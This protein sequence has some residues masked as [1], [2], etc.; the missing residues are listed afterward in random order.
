[1]DLDGID[2]DLDAVVEDAY[3]LREM[4]HDW[5]RETRGPLLVKDIEGGECKNFWDILLVFMIV[6]VL[7]YVFMMM[8][9]GTVEATVLAR[10]ATKKVHS[11]VVSI[12]PAFVGKT[13]SSM[14]RVALPYVAPVVSVVENDT[15]K[16]AI[17]RIV[18]ANKQ[19]A[20]YGKEQLFSS[21]LTALIPIRTKA[22]IVKNA[23]KTVSKRVIWC[24]RAIVV[25][26][27]QKEKG[28]AEYSAFL[29]VMDAACSMFPSTTLWKK[30]A[31]P[32][33]RSGATTVSAANSVSAATSA[34][35]STVSADDSRLGSPPRLNRRSRRNDA[36]PTSPPRG[37]GRQARAPE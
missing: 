29:T 19:I 33:E 13:L 7:L 30:E 35:V 6:C 2:A 27:F 21:L 18:L 5:W 15:V 25:F 8:Q 23:S 20:P 32:V 16:Q 28:W 11:I 22:Y 14:Y 3:S 12:A 37:V 31:V 24:L 26:A 1:M 9:S 10:A 36:F 17:D 4:L 34:D